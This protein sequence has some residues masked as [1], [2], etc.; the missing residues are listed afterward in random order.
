MYT[1]IRPTMRLGSIESKC[2]AKIGLKTL[3]KVWIKLIVMPIKKNACYAHTHT[4]IYIY[5]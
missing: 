2:V 5:I 4:H 1:W 3:N